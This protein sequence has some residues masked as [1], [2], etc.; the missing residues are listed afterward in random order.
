TVSAERVDTATLDA[1]YWFTNLR[2]TVRFH[3]AIEALIG[4]GHH[5]FVEVSPHPVLTM[6]I[7]ETLDASEVRGVA[8]GSLRRA[9]DDVECLLS[10]AAELFVT[11]TNVDWS[12]AVPALG[13]VGRRVPL[14]TYAFQ[15]DRYWLNAGPVAGDTTGLGLGAIAHPLL[16]AV[17]GLPDGER[18]LLTGRLTAHTQPWLTDHTVLGSVLFPGSGFIELATQAGDQV[19]CGYI[20]ELVL[21]APLVIS[22]AGV[23]LRIVVGGDE[24]GHRAIEIYTRDE[25]LGAE[26][27]AR[28]ASGV[29]ASDAT[30]FDDLEPWT[31]P[32]AGA[33]PVDITGFYDRQTAVGYGPAFQGLRSAWRDG[34]D[35]Y[36]EVGLPT[37]T[38]D[39]GANAAG[40]ALHPALLDAA[41]HAYGLAVPTDTG[42]P[43]LPFTW[44]GVAVRAEGASILRV[45]LRVTEADTLSLVAFDPAGAP[46]LTVESLVLRP[47]SAEQLRPA[48][49]AESR[50]LYGLDWVAAPAGRPVDSGRWAIIDGPGA[51]VLADGLSGR[52]IAARIVAGLDELAGAQAPEF[53]V[54]PVDPGEEATLARDAVSRTLAVLQAWVA[55]PDWEPSRL[56][57]VTRGAVTAVAGEPVADLSGAAV[58]GL[59]RSAQAEHPDRFVLVD[60]DGQADDTGQLAAAVACGEPQS[61]IRAGVVLV[62]RLTRVLAADPRELRASGTVLITGGTGVLGTALARHLAQPDGPRL[63]LVSR[64]G[65][66]AP[67]TEAVLAELRA[68]GA[69]AEAAACDIADRDALAELLAGI[70][71]ERP[72]TAVIHAA[73]VL[74][75]GMIAAQTPDRLDT[76]FAPKAMAAW[77]LH[78]LT[79]ELPSVSAFV[80]FSSAAG[81]IGNA[82]QSNYAAAN[83][84]LDGLAAYRRGHGLPAVSLGWGMW[85]QDSGMTGHL[86]RDD[87]DRLSRSG[88]GALPTE[89]A[90]ALFDLAVPSD[91]PQLL[92]MRLNIKALREQ[93]AAGTLPPLLRQLVPAGRRRAMANAAGGDAALAERLAGLPPDE[94]RK[95]VIDLIRGTVARVLGYAES[96][97]VGI[98]RSFVELGFDSLTAIELRNRLA[99]AT[100]L[101]LSA[102]LVFDRPT[103]AELTDYLLDRLEPAA[104]APLAGLLDA[105][106]KGLDRIADL[107]SANAPDADA[108]VLGRLERLEA[109]I[110]ELR[111]RDSVGTEKRAIEELSDEEMFSFISQNLNVTE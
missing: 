60:A 29:L 72:L 59:V 16:G 39:A 4:A 95:V 77:H 3:E 107:T 79:A 26:Q 55:A 64:R 98:D 53:V 13:I 43:G 51:Q 9:E 75:D 54:L 34:A 14:P 58:S 66:D 81:T 56:V 11:G 30:E 19:G 85:A 78:E 17:V 97:A 111:S 47:V 96:G 74:D 31:W 15:H 82:G 91:R 70:P 10:A 28:H 25:T 57:V 6:G 33:E 22:D 103:S 73:G 23:D 100:G 44:T 42:S 63:L 89:D 86:S 52:G 88:S 2:Q 90:L 94:R 84:F 102:T 32:P 109:R 41:L 45:R 69:E 110:A 27:W 5:A 36:A 80:L 83:A 101:R 50:D 93:A 20:E 7:A 40:F 92:P 71:A 61:A 1:G 46:V 87:R 67:D 105:L 48:Q 76:V 65:P 106:D 35:I 104:R 68:L 62:P 99:E 37:Q 38:G 18:V 21:E 12:A 49:G 24:D 8:V 108:E